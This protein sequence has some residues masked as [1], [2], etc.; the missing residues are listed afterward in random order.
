MLPVNYKSLTALSLLVT[1]LLLASGCGVTLSPVKR[2]PLQIA[3]LHPAL[4]PDSQ[5]MLLQFESTLP[6]TPLA[7]TVWD[8]VG[9][10]FVD[11]TESKQIGFTQDYSESIPAEMVGGVPAAVAVETQPSYTRIVIPFGRIFEGVFQS[12]FQNVFTNSIVC[13]DT[14]C[15]SNQ[16]TMLPRYI[17]KLKITS[18]KVWEQPL[19]HLNLQATVECKLD[20]MDKTNEPEFVYEAQAKVTQQSIGSILSTSRG[21]IKSMNKISNEFATTLSKDILEKVRNK[22]QEHGAKTASLMP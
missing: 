11:A 21:F 14:S 3:A 17:L 19:N 20:W 6:E 4:A 9:G 12:G 22:L 1:T 7:E 2:A 18:F 5:P 8:N 13:A 15:V 16:Q 10:A